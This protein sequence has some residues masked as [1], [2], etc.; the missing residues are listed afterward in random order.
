MTLPSSLDLGEV[1]SRVEDCSIKSKVRAT[2]QQISNQRLTHRDDICVHII[3]WN[4]VFPCPSQANFC[5]GL[6]LLMLFSEFFPLGHKHL[7]ARYRTQ[8]DWHGLR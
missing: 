4:I 8:Q 1:H 2:L 3:H 6:E 7:E 5:P